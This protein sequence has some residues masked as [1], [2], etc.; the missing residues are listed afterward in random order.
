MHS[1]LFVC[2]GNACRSQM[3]EGFARYYG[4]QDLV[5]YS[6]GSAPLGFVVG[7]AIEVMREKGIDI[8]RRHSKGLEEIPDLE[9]D[10]AV[11]MGCG[12]ACPMARARQKIEW[13][14]P[15]P[16]GEPVA[17]FR[18]T[19]NLIERKVQRLLKDLGP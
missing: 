19:R 13:E 2:V 17:V 16:V 3:A 14:I 7:E 10:V 18:K 5:V 11:L 15:D 9:F 6:A 12:D 8:S 1:I 4:P